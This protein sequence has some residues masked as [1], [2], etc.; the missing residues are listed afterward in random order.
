MHRNREEGKGREGSGHV[1]V[2]WRQRACVRPASYCNLP[3]THPVKTMTPRSGNGCAALTDLIPRSLWETQVQVQVCLVHGAERGFRARS[4][5]REWV[6][7]VRWVGEGDVQSSV[8]DDS[9]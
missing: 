8:P 6:E 3:E 7:W 9:R 5:K 1:Q 4:R 2:R